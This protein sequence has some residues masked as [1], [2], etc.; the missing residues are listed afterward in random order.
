MPQNA[1]KKE[2]TPETLRAMVKKCFGEE[3]DMRSFRPLDEGYCNMAYA[4]ELSDGRRVICKI[5]PEDKSCLLRVEVNLMQAE[6]RAMELVQE[7]TRVPVAPVYQ[8][9]DSCTVCKSPYFFMKELKGQS[10]SSVRDSLPLAVKE[11]IYWELGQMERRINQVTHDTFGFVGDERTFADW[12]SAFSRMMEDLFLDAKAKDIDFGVSFDTLRACLLQDEDCFRDVTVPQ[13]I[14]WD[15]WDGN[16]FVLDGHICGIID[17]ERA[18]WGDPL[19]DDRF[20]R[21]E[22]SEAFLTGYGQK[23]FSNSETRRI[24]WYDLFLYGVMM[25][26]GAYRGYPN[27]SQYQWVKPLFAQSFQELQSL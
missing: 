8:Y 15:L 6:V 23:E 7:K 1:M 14:H 11:G 4:M 21:H 18:L 17:W 25:T 24:L 13:L 5:A 16:V 9:D 2:Q 27:D 22:R 20:R 3:M 10:L 26:E 19:M 12:F